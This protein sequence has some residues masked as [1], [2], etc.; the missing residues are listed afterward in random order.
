MTPAPL[1][2]RMSTILRTRWSKMPCI[3]KSEAMVRAN[4]LSTS[5]S[6]RSVATTVASSPPSG[7][8]VGVP[9]NDGAMV[10][11]ALKL[12]NRLGV[13]GIRGVRDR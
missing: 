1:T 11:A 7:L 3:G 13:R 5:T 4:S 2:G 8:R 10:L 9:R 6:C 12:H